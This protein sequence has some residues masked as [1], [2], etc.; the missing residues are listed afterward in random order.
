MKPCIL[1]SSTANGKNL[2][3][4]PQTGALRLARRVAKGGARWAIT[5]LGPNVDKKNPRYKYIENSLN[6][7]KKF[8]LFDFF[9]QKKWQQIFLISVL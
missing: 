1:T 5:P 8:N 6:I 9:N 7:M 2:L 4:F 3:F